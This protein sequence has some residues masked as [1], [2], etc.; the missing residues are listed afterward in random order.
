VNDVCVFKNGFKGLATYPYATA[1]R[2]SCTLDGGNCDGAAQA[3]VSAQTIAQEV[4]GKFSVPVCT[5]GSSS[6][7]CVGVAGVPPSMFGNPEAYWWSNPNV[8]Q[9]IGEFFGEG[10]S[11]ASGYCYKL[12]GMNGLSAY[13]AVVDRCAGK[14][15]NIFF[16]LF[17]KS[18][19]ESC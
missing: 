16:F 5:T 2:K 12:T 1:T 14:F 19:R 8:N 6:T 13:I 7:D 18:Y 10:L 11:F 4:A 9:A 3:F 17:I 15:I